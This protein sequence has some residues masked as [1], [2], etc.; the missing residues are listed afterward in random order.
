V[1]E[2]ALSDVGNPF[3]IEWP[4]DECTLS[5]TVFARIGM[6]IVQKSI[7]SLLARHWS[8]E[9]RQK[10]MRCNEVEGPT[11]RCRFFCAKR[12]FEAFLSTRPRVLRLDDLSAPGSC[13]CDEPIA[14][15]SRI[16]NG[17]DEAIPFKWLDVVR[18]RAAVHDKSSGQ[19][20]HRRCSHTKDLIQNRQLRHT[21]AAGCERLIIE[22][23]RASRCFSQRRTIAVVLRVSKA[24]PH[25]PGVRSQNLIR[26]RTPGDLIKDP[27]G[28]V[29]GSW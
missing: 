3:D 22:L 8:L 18:Q 1:S 10:T 19:F 27:S 26:L 17:L 20:T 14:P 2:A 4:P 15:V 21:K 6:K 24:R 28:V 23:R 16:S 12:S 9:R 25:G 5:R 11:Q 13:K 7:H 29:W